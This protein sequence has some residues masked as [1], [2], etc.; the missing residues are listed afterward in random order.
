MIFYKKDNN[1]DKQL[2]PGLEPKGVPE[3]LIGTSIPFYYNDLDS[4]NRVI[5]NHKDEI[6]VIIMEPQRGAPPQKGFLEFIFI[7]R[8]F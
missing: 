8:S 5:D 1:L 7:L 6:G 2:L 4:F 3:A